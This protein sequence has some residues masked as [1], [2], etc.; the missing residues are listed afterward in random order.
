M[1]ADARDQIEALW[2]KHLN[3]AD[4]NDDEGAHVGFSQYYRNVAHGLALALN[5]MDGHTETQP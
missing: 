1:S 2:R 5:I 3:M 4:A